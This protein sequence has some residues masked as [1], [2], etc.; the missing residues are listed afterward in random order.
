MFEDHSVTKAA[1]VLGLHLDRS[2]DS[3]FFFDQALQW[4]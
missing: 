3:H 1:G 2:F 4:I